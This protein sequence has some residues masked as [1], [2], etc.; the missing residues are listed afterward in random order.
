MYIKRVFS[1]LGGWDELMLSNQSEYSD[2]L[3]A[4]SQFTEEN[5]SNPKIS[6]PYNSSQDEKINITPYCFSNALDYFLKES[7]W[8]DYRV[9]PSQKGGIHLYAHNL[10][11]GV[12]TQL[13]ADERMRSFPSWLYVQVPRLHEEGITNLSVML[14]PEEDIRNS[15]EESARLRMLFTGDRCLAQ[16]TE[17]SPLKSKAPFVVLTYSTELSDTSP[18]I[19][20]IEADESIVYVEKNIIEK[21]IE[22]P[23]EYYQAGIGILSYFGE[24]LKAKHPDLNAKIRIEQDNG[25]VRLHIHSQNGDKE[26]IE[27]ALE[28]YTLVVAD[29][30]KPESLFEDQVQI[31]TLNHKL[32]MAKMEV[33]QTHNMLMLSESKSEHKLRTLEDDVKYMRNLLADQLSHTQSTTNHIAKL[34]HQSGKLIKVHTDHNCKMM[35][36]LIDQASFSKSVSDALV[37]I[38]DKLETGIDASDEAEVK[39]SLTIVHDDSPDLIPMLGELLKSSAYGVSG[40]IAYQWFL[41]VCAVL[42]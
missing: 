28:D 19:I 37:L 8:N 22:F 42:P 10:K 25:I 40:N 26:V 30:A 12:S 9:K 5:L 15:F 27:K 33:R 17:L 23:P 3:D 7:D 24:V 4:L 11:N 16:L 31:M 41:S 13:V 38:K 6:R 18:T 2:I 32:E 35:E 39:K 20:E 34:A 29:K 36:S 21:S 1:Y 14:V